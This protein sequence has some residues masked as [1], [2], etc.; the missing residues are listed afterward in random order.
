MLHV[1]YKRSRS[2]YLYYCI[3]NT[4]S[5]LIFIFMPLRKRKL[6]IDYVGSR[7]LFD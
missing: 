5:N 1:D 2:F 7:L 3:E 6:K 4:H